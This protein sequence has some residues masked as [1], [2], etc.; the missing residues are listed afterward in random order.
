MATDR[1]VTRVVSPGDAQLRD[2]DSI[3]LIE[4]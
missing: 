1:G 3:Y 4:I 2:V